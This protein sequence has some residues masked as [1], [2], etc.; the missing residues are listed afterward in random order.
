[1]SLLKNIL[2]CRKKPTHKITNRKESAFIVPQ[3]RNSAEKAAKGRITQARDSQEINI[4]TEI[5]NKI[6][7]QNY[8][9][10]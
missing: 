6:Q 5:K 2:T 4:K 10:K 8:Q 9:T 7:G 1:M 3:R